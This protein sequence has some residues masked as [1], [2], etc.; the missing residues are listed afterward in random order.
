MGVVEMNDS[1]W[2]SHATNEVAAASVSRG[3]DS[4]SLF[5]CCDFSGAIGDNQLG[6]DA[7]PVV[8]AEVAARDCAASCELNG[9]AALDWHSP[10]PGGP[11]T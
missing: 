6:P 11:D 1:Q 5:S 10:H 7:V 8:R 3:Q 9:N 2:G 4:A